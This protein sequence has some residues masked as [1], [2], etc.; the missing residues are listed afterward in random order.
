MLVPASLAVTVSVSDIDGFPIDNADVSI[1]LTDDNSLLNSGI[2]DEFG[3]FK[4]ELGEDQDSLDVFILAE[5]S[6]YEKKELKTS[7]VK[8]EITEIKLKKIEETGGGNAGLG[9]AEI[10]TI[11]VVDKQTKTIISNKKVTLSLSCG[12][13][14]I[15]PDYFDETYGEFKVNKPGNC[16]PLYATASAEGYVDSTKQAVLKTP[17]L[18][19][20]TKGSLKETKGK[21][22]VTVYDE[23]NNSL[24]DITVL[25][26]TA[27]NIDKRELVTDIFG[28]VLFDD[29]TP[30][31][32]NISATQQNDKKI[33]RIADKKG[34]QVNSGKIKEETLNFS[35]FG[36]GIYKIIFKVIDGK[37][38]NAVS[39]VGIIL[40]KNG[41]Q[42]KVN[43]SYTDAEGKFTLILDEPDKDA[44]F[45]ALL[46][47]DGYVPKV[48]SLNVI[49]KDSTE[50]QE[51]LLDKYNKED[52]LN[53]KYGTVLVT[54]V[55]EE[56]LPVENAITSIFD[57][58][59]GIPFYTSDTNKD[60][61]VLFEPLPAGKYYAKAANE[62]NTKLGQSDSQELKNGETL[63]IQVKLTTGKTSIEVIALNAK[64]LGQR[65][66]KA[67]AEFYSIPANSND[68]SIFVT[69]CVTNK[70]GN[71]SVSL[72]TKY[73]DVY[74]KVSKEGYMSYIAGNNG[75]NI[76]LVA[77]DNVQVIAK[78]Y[79]LAQGDPTS[80]IAVHAIGVY[81]G[82]PWGMKIGDLAITLGSDKETELDYYAL[83][84]VFVYEPD[85]DAN[86]VYFNIRTGNEKSGIVSIMDYV[87]N[88]GDPIF[89]DPIEPLRIPSLKTVSVS[90]CTD[91]TKPE[92]TLFK[93][94]N[95][96]TQLLKGKSSLAETTKLANTVIPVIIHFKVR[97]NVQLGT[98]VTLI[99]NT[100]I[101]K[102]ESIFDAESGIIN[103]QI[104]DSMTL[105]QIKLQCQQLPQGK[106]LIWQQLTME[107]DLGGGAE[108]VISQDR[109][110]LDKQNNIWNFGSV[111]DPLLSLQEYFLHYIIFNCSEKEKQ[112][113]LLRLATSGTFTINNQSLQEFSNVDI[114]GYSILKEP[115]KTILNFPPQDME[116]PTKHV[117]DINLLQS[118]NVLMQAKVN[119]NVANTDSLYLVL[120]QTYLIPDQ[121][122]IISG[123][124]LTGKK[125]KIGNANIKL[126]KIVG[127]QYQEITTTT[128]EN[129]GD[130]KGSFVVLVS[131]KAK[132]GDVYQLTASKNAHLPASPIIIKVAYPSNYAQ[133]KCITKSDKSLDYILSNNSI[134]FTLE[135]KCAV[136]LNI[137]FVDQDNEFL[138]S[139]AI[140]EFPQYPQYPSER[141]E[142]KSG[143]LIEVT[144]KAKDNIIQGIHPIYLTASNDF[145]KKTSAGLI[146]VTV[147]DRTSA[148]SLQ[149]L[150]FDFKQ[151]I[152]PTPLFNLLNSKPYYQKMPDEVSLAWLLDYF[153]VSPRIVETAVGD[154]FSEPKC[155][156]KAGIKVILTAKYSC[157]DVDFTKEKVL[158]DQT[159]ISLPVYSPKLNNMADAVTNLSA[160][161]KKNCTGKLKEQIEEGK[162]T[163]IDTKGIVKFIDDTYFSGFYTLIIK[164]YGETAFT[165]YSIDVYP[166]RFWLESPI[167]NKE[168]DF[169]AWHFLFGDLKSILI[170]DY[171]INATSS[172]VF[173][174]DAQNLFNYAQNLFN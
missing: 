57:S 63:N 165:A 113:L 122:I 158:L 62:Q 45:N 105:D 166:D 39:D 61:Q 135:N 40:Y 134:T 174:N 112:N 124:T 79:E 160:E 23:K 1:L 157:Y 168:K 130:S 50:I 59:T 88:Q 92:E 5:A 8:G 103:R 108:T 161:A 91:L 36:G 82:E 9:E 35:A 126:N 114:G 118:S 143:K 94:P 111:D 102:N 116:N 42:L 144:L 53:V 83:F 89:L 96:P 51:F 133:I 123:E 150:V 125:A 90:S 38:K 154:N 71:C 65:I 100:K 128:S 27:D 121:P 14:S 162:P 153:A 37:D 155:T 97:R 67:L 60:G 66:E 75:H 73:Q 93:M 32:Y 98:V 58:V 16:T 52:P 84:D 138:Y 104:G 13:G 127:D 15:D 72:D 25:V 99:S 77:N 110:N 173:K 101:S 20:M 106:G 132:I 19:E 140:S 55:D 136:D 34:I 69:S 17:Y 31:Q 47:K 22:K 29:L 115:E 26:V 76:I 28:S 170:T 43:K 80:G 167:K 164:H 141:V 149:S 10:Y 117:L 46:Y 109:S 3:E 41:V 131:T 54:V 49:P 172:P 11:K 152:T 163:D 81:N 78:L 48:V 56:S 147:S 159:Q 169:N 74:V 24:Q 119:C 86:N 6:G 64:N 70:D 171:A 107:K 44:T 145:I 146:E 139:P 85:E 4:F 120:D 151:G 30:G 2:T 21:L 33:T 95:C 148:F 68:E 87:N 129:E 142:L 7:I 18:I 12:S 137:D 156:E